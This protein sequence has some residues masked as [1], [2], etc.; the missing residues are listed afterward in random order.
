[1]AVYVWEV[2]PDKI[3]AEYLRNKWRCQNIINQLE[4]FQIQQPDQADT[5]Q[6]KIN[7]L[8]QERDAWDNSIKNH[9][10]VDEYAVETV[11]KD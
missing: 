3:L 1:M 6:E 9:K 8:T 10:K 4:S 11:A 5:V 2:E 7:R